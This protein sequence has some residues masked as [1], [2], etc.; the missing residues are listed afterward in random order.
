MSK[1][2]ARVYHRDMDAQWCTAFEGREVAQLQQA[3]DSPPQP[4]QRSEV[5]RRLKEV[6]ALLPIFAPLA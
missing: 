5:S 3:A 2:G 1:C 6:L 4:E